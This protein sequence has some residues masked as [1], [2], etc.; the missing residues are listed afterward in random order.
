[1]WQMISNENGRGEDIEEEGDR[2]LDGETNWKVI[3]KEKVW[4]KSRR[5]TAGWR[6]L[7]RNSD[8]V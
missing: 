7:V 8:S 3:C 6:G 2:N 5:K 1:M 4:E